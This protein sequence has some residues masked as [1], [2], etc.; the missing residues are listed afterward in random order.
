M[1]LSVDIHLARRQA[2]NGQDTKKSEK[3]RKKE[4]VEIVK[5]FF[6]SCR[7]FSPPVSIVVRRD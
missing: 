2:Q 5:L 1:L 7:F 4:G 3:E 6:L